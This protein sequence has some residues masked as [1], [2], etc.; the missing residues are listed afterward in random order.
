MLEV[1][2]SDNDALFKLLRVDSLK[3]LE[4]HILKEQISTFSSTSIG[5]KSIIDFEVPQTLD[6]SLELL[7]ETIEIYNLEFEENIQ[8]SLNGFHDIKDKIDVCFKGG[9]INADDLLEIYQTLSL[10]LIHI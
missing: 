8:I 7:G 10:S 6:Q 9:V 4:W 2:K 5:R 1:D 3:L